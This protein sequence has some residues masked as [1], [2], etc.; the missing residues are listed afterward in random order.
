LM[1]ALRP[2]SPTL[3]AAGAFGGNFQ[4][5]SFSLPERG[6]FLGGYSL[7]KLL[8]SGSGEGDQARWGSLSLCFYLAF[9][10]SPQDT[11]VG[12]KEA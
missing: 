10:P 2:Q 3:L 12:A 5:G 7:V 6:F 9:D 11:S 4:I 1:G 8:F